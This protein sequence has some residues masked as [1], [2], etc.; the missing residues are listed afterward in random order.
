MKV[1]KIWM[2]PKNA[3]MGSL[4]PSMT[5]GDSMK[6]IKIAFVIMIISTI[7]L[8]GCSN[9]LAE[10]HL[11]NASNDEQ[12]TRPD[13]CTTS[14]SNI[15]SSSIISESA[16]N[17]VADSFIIPYKVQVV[18]LA[19]VKEIKGMD[20]AGLEA[21]FRNRREY[22]P[23]D[24]AIWSP[25]FA[26]DYLS[27][28]DIYFDESELEIDFEHEVGI[29]SIHRKIDTFFLDL[30]SIERKPP[31]LVEPPPDATMAQGSDSTT[32]PHLLPYAGCVLDSDYFPD[33]IFVYT[34]DYEATPFTIE[35][36]D[37]LFYYG[38]NFILQ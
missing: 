2:L 16:S 14:S 30:D 31:V 18:E 32:T 3:L 26:P 4:I 27:A 21:R 11:Q 25:L 22:D 33:S 24:F 38:Y 36:D 34:M 35:L 7:L 17:I 15:T 9:D 5:N 1:N 28:D 29:I 10:S 6:H 37:I 20:I 8:C 23:N 13:D 12:N 19:Y